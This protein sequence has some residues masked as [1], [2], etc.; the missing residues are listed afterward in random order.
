MQL[1]T[2][3]KK[4]LQL[5]QQDAKQTTKELSVKTNL[6][7]TA[8]YE[9]VKKLEKNKII[10]K[11]TAL[12]DKNQ[13]GKSFTV[14]CHIK[15]VKPEKEIIHEFEKE[16]SGL[17]EVMECFHVSGEY[18]YILKVQVADMDAFREFMVNKLTTIKSIGSTQSS[19]S[20][21]EVKNTTEFDI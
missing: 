2:I 19:I 7:V 14:F 10:R 6:S 13:I 12:L 15:L 3:D 1:D 16:I 4:I 21:G 5:L 8:V 20:I 9:R 17:N 18:D 11:F